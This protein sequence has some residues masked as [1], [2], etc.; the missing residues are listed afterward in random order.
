MHK[1]VVQKN[2]IHPDIKT[3]SLLVFFDI[4]RIF[5]IQKINLF[6]KIQKVDLIFK[7]Q[8]NGCI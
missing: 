3:L 8:K 2:L 5:E 1:K 7:I 4:L 6:F